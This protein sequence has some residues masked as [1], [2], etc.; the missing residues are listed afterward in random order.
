MRKVHRVQLEAC[1]LFGGHSSRRAGS[2][3]NA[4][5]TSSC[6]G[7]TRPLVC[8]YRTVRYSKLV[9]LKVD[10]EASFTSCADAHS[11]TSLQGGRGAMSASLRARRPETISSC[12]LQAKKQ[13]WH[14]GC[15]LSLGLCACSHPLPQC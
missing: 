5:S 9:L 15:C 7:G 6:R 1:Y 14:V 8:R 3:S 4:G 10:L 13:A 2:L 11:L 12:W